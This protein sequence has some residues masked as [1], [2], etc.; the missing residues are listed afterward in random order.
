MI[1]VDGWFFHASGFR[2]FVTFIWMEWG[3]LDK[4]I[5]LLFIGK[6]FP[7]GRLAQRLA[8]RLYTPLVTGSNPVSPTNYRP[9]NWGYSQ[10]SS[11][12]GRSYGLWLTQF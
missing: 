1:T 2:A 9:D 12:I 11:P 6:A 4:W 8:Q 3:S 10:S 5:H 7:G